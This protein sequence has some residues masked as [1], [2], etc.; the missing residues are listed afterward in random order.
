MKQATLI[1]PMQSTSAPP[2]PAA[3]STQQTSQQVAAAQLPEAPLTRIMQDVAAKATGPQVV[4]LYVQWQNVDAL[5][6]LDVLLCPLVHSPTLT[7]L[8]T[9]QRMQDIEGTILSM[10]L[11]A[12]RQ[13][14]GVLEAL[15]TRAAQQDAQARAENP[16]QQS[17]TTPAVN[18]VNKVS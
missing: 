7:A 1:Q 5:C 17:S 8:M 2:Q 4:N 12:Y 3:A 10:L 13:A 9:P 15:L 11:K 18:I 16:V 14:Q 6:W